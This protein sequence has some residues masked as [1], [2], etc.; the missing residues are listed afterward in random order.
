MFNM[1]PNNHAEVLSR[2][3]TCKRAAM[4]LMKKYAQQESP[5]FSEENEY[6]DGRKVVILDAWHQDIRNLAKVGAKQT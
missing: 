3:P 4:G 1:V 5:N 2:V 6:R